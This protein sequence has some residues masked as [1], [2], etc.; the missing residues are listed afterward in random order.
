MEGSMDRVTGTIRPAGSESFD[1]DAWIALL[2]RRP[3][4]RR[5]AAREMKNPFTGKTQAVQPSQDAA[6]VLA[7]GEVLGEAYWSMSDDPLV[8]VSIARSAMPLVSEWAK[9]LGGEFHEDT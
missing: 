1:R 7:F 8:N 4:F 5:H 6:E 9:E 3:E 2:N